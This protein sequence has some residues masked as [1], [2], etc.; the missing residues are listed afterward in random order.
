MSSMSRSVGV[1]AVAAALLLLCGC[2]QTTPDPGT[3]VG[4]G[5][6]TPTGGGTGDTG[7]EPD[8]GGGGTPGPGTGG[9]TGPGRAITGTWVGD[10]TCVTTL[11]GGVSLV[12]GETTEPLTVTFDEAGQPDAL[13]LILI[14]EANTT[15][16]EI[17]E[18]GLSTNF[19]LDIELDFQ[20]MLL[21]QSTAVA[22]ADYGVDAAVVTFTFTFIAQNSFERR[23]G[24]GEQTIKFEVVDDA[25]EYEAVAT[26]H[27]TQTILVNNLNTTNVW[28]QTSECTG[29]LAKQ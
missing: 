13:R 17:V 10:V 2:P 29:T 18:Q 14:G 20:T 4:G 22:E 3:P 11:T 21:T 28:R 27:V 15:T 9:Q 1:A 12:T 25:L 19:S 7:N 26:Y 23:E 6:G 5:G 24:T 8:P 16:V